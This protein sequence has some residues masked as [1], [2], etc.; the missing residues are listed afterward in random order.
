MPGRPVSQT[1][2]P[3]LSR[4][5]G[6]RA[7]PHDDVQ[8]GLPGGPEEALDVVSAGEAVPP[9]GVGGSPGRT[10]VSTVL[11]PRAA[12]RSSQSAPLVGVD[13]EV[14]QRSRQDAVRAPGPQE[15]AV[16]VGRRPGARSSDASDVS[17][18]MQLPSVASAPF[19]GATAGTMAD[20]VRNAEDVADRLRPGGGTCGDAAG[21][22]VSGE[23]NGYASDTPGTGGGARGETGG[24]RRAAAR[25]D[26]C[27]PARR[28]VRA[29]GVP[30]PGRPSERRPKTRAKVLAAVE[31]RATAGTTRRGRCPSSSRTIGVVTL[32]TDSSSRTNLTFGIETAA[33]EAGYTVSADHRVAGHRRDRG[34]PV[35]AGGQ[36]RRGSRPLRAAGPRQS[37]DRAAHPP[38]AD[39]HRRRV[40]HPG[41]RGRRRRPGPGGQSGDSVALIDLA[42]SVWRVAGPEEVVRRRPPRRLARHP[43][44]RG[45][46]RPA[47]AGG[48]LDARLRVPQRPGPGADTQ[49]V[50]AVFV[51]SDEMAF[52]VIRA[53]HELGRKVPEDV[54]GRRGRHRAGQYCSPSLTT[55][56]QPFTRMGALA[57][58]HLL[59]AHR[60]PGRDD[61][62]RHRRAKTSSCAPSTAPPPARPAEAGPADLAAGQPDGLA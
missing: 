37:A 13:A 50:T 44:G 2:S 52:G 60:G 46:G 62:T 16:R 9:D 1:G 38:G 32:Q 61:R 29:D 34:G 18:A 6:C 22:A 24:R 39:R 43:G 19:R 51:A 17:D 35:P 3:P 40:T 12:T 41:H 30:D 31:Q 25:D 55:V 26:R 36:G 33:R 15:P 7:G 4:S 10:Y 47:G 23:A 53:L 59:R 58:A 42:S 45:P 27:R 54:R 48:R 56:A 28:G 21:A 57:V 8:A 49:G 20:G 14:V 5:A 11:R